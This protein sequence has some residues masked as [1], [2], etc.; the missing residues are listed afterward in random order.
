MS[1]V[2]AIIMDTDLTKG[3]VP[4][5][6]KIQLDMEKVKA[7]LAELRQLLP[8]PEPHDGTLGW[9]MEEI[10]LKVQLTVQG[11]V[12]LIASAGLTGGIE[13]KFTRKS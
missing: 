13:V 12:Q 2:E 7:E 11:G 10:T 5:L 6:S 3:L 9:T 1:R 4:G 8:D